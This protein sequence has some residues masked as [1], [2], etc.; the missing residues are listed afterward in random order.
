MNE[1]PPASH[2]TDPETSRLAEAEVT[3]NGKRGA[4]CEKVRELVEQYPGHT[5]LELA[6]VQNHLDRYQISRRLSDLEDADVVRKGLAR[7]CRVGRRQMVTWWLEV[8]QGE[9]F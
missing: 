2:S 3:N 1:Y 6:A 5:S 8:G 4:Q 7:A 9:L